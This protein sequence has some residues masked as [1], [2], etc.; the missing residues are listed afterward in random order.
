VGVSDTLQVVLMAHALTI[1]MF[2]RELVARRKQRKTR[3]ILQVTLLL[4]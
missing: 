2:F 4:T 3:A 1:V